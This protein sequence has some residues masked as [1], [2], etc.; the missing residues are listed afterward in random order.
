VTRD[1]RRAV[2]LADTTDVDLRPLRLLGLAL[3]QARTP[4]IARPHFLES[5]EIAREL[6]AEYEVALTLRAMADTRFED[7]ETLRLESDAI[8]GRLGVASVPSVPLP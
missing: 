1:Y 7:A 4:E 8:L 3:C 5:L 2:A 6:Q